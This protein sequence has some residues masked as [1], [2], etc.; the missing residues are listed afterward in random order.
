[1]KLGLIGAGNMASALARGIGEPVL[2]SD[3]DRARALALAEQLG[4]EALESNAEVAERADAVLLCHKPKQL[5]EVAAEVAGHTDTVVSILAATTT[6]SLSRAYPGAAIYRFL[7]NMPAEVG[8]GVLCYVAGPGAAEGPEEEILGLMGRVGEVIRLVDEPL[9]EPAMALMS[10]G[11]AFMALVAEAFADAGAAHGLDPHDAMR[12]VV[13]TM[14]G[15][16]DYLAAHDYDGPALRRRV[17]TPGGTTERGLIALEDGGLDR[18][19]RS[20]VDTVVE[21]TR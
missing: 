21:G 1:M 12:M 11:P 20:A 6:D 16:A 19:A 7:P 4:G 9:I 10:C 8:R 14:G 18:L 17:A 2:V 3:I 15:T 13:E 5:D